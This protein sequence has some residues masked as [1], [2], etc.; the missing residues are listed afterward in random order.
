MVGEDALQN[1]EIRA[2]SCVRIVGT[3]LMQVHVGFDLTSTMPDEARLPTD[4]RH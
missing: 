2:G 3:E 4:Q 1:R